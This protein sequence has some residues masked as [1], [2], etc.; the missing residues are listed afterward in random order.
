MFFLRHSSKKQINLFDP[1]RFVTHAH[2]CLK[3]RKNI[4]SKNRNYIRE[5]NIVRATILNC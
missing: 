1:N 4:H 3:K 5:T 2:P